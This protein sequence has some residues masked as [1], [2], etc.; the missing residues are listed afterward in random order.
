LWTGSLTVPTPGGVP[1]TFSGSGSALFRLLT[2]L[3]QQY[4][5]TLK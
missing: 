3:D 2:S 1:A 4:R 5:A